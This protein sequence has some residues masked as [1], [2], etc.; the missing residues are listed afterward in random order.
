M[1]SPIRDSNIAI[2]GGGAAG[3]F[4]A[5]ACA[6]SQPGRQVI[7]LERTSAVLGKVKISGGG[8]CNVTHA[9]FEPERLVRFYP[10]GAQALRGPFS[11]FQPRDTVEWFARRGV[12]LKTEEDGRIFPR[13]DCSQ[14]IIDCLCDAAGRAGVVVRRQVIVD[15]I[16]QIQDSRA[17]YALSL[18]S[19]EELQAACLI[20]ATG[21]NPQGW[22]WARDLGHHIEPPVA[23]LFTFAVP[24][25]RLDGLLGVSVPQA[26]LRLAGTRHEQSGAVLITHWGLSGPAVLRLSAWAARD[27]HA[28]GYRAELRVN[29]LADQSAEHVDQELRR[30]RHRHARQCAVSTSPFGLP[31]RLWARLAGAAGIPPERR[32]N[33]VS[34]QELRALT[35]EL[36]DGRYP[37]TG[38]SLFKDEFVT[39]GG[40]RLDEVDFRTLESK[41]CRGLYFAGEILDIDAVTGGFNFQ[42]AWTTG[43]IAGKAAAADSANSLFR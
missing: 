19:G 1:P 6:E 13:S 32:W 40:V 25:A 5:I 15:N 30:L 38:K 18:G 36:L 8:R 21:S 9:C 10:R 37:M 34:N 41:C 28:C 7:V 20:L 12:E 29:W 33:G 39:C 23:S 27:F 2:I 11:R 24:D 35:A 16:A 42:N 3:F 26:R 4:A 17:R 43:W 22:Q 14:T 31:K